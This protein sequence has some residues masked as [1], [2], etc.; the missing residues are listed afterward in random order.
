MIVVIEDSTSNCPKRRLSPSRITSTPDEIGLP[1]ASS[2]PYCIKPSGTSRS[3]SRAVPPNLWMMAGPCLSV[4]NSAPTHQSRT[5]LDHIRNGY[6]LRSS[7]GLQYGGIFEVLCCATSALMTFE[8]RLGPSPSSSLLYF[9][10]CSF[11]EG[12]NR[13]V[14]SVAAVSPRCVRPDRSLA[15][16]PD[17][18]RSPCRL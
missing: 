10:P 13:D 14:A 3:N 9:L 6:P 2:R 1:I 8:S 17:A 18:G 4:F 12:A 11:H 7:S 15:E 5:S 16:L